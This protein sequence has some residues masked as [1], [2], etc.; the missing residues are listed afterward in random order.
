MSV[1]LVDVLALDDDTGWA[2]RCWWLLRH[3][4]HDAA[5]TMD[6]RGYPGSFSE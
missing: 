4:S 1:L 6:V 5:G 3:L 2:A